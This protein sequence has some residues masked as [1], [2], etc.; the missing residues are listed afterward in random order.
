MKIRKRSLDL[1]ILE[2]VKSD[3]LTKP[4]RQSLDHIRTIGNFAAHPSPK[5]SREPTSGDVGHNGPEHDA[6]ST[7]IDVSPSEA[8]YT[9][10]VLELL[11]RDLIVTP[12][13]AQGMQTLLEKSQS[14]PSPPAKGTT[15]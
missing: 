6:A 7:I 10:H 2:A 13:R 9:L 11:F 1:E 3:A 5:D 8:A 12:T 15:P 14:P 4:T